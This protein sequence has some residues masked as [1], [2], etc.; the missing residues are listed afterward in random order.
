MVT[1]DSIKAKIQALIA[2]VNAAT[3]KNDTD[4][5]SGVNALIEGYGAGSDNEY[6]EKLK[7]LVERMSYME[8]T[9][10]DLDGI[11]R[12]GAGA[13]ARHTYLSKI[14]L[15]NTIAGIE[16]Y[17]FEASSITDIVIPDKC[18]LIRSYA[19]NSCSSLKSID[20][21][22]GV[23][24][25]GDQC[26]GYSKLPTIT[27]PA[28]LKT[29][30]NNVFYQNQ[31]HTELLTFKGTTPPTISVNSLS[32]LKADCVIFV[33]VEAVNEYRIATNWSVRANYIYPIGYDPSLEMVTIH[34][35]S[36]EIGQIDAPKVPK[37]MTWFDM[38]NSGN[39]PTYEAGSD[40][41]QP[42]FSCASATSSVYYISNQE[43]Y[44]NEERT[45]KL[46]GSML[47]A[48][49]MNVYLK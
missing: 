23:Q 21:G 9:A 18:T 3:G 11:Y 43:L 45:E 27:F 31:N 32:G 36:K 5:T 49:E 26:F 41:I 10:E 6:K 35:I 40:G 12:I 19:F 8:L 30:G 44:T 1:A 42:V 14:T 39:A 33:P 20:L 46:N 24:T 28:S 25:I 22:N 38:L 37:G 4:L 29:L 15:P 16:G 47:I 34:V 7:A 48:G 17:A 2:K 13:F